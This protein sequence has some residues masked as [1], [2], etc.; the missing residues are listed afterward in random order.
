VTQ[1]V[2]PGVGDSADYSGNFADQRKNSGKNGVLGRSE[3][4]S[5]DHKLLKYLISAEKFRYAVE[6]RNK[7]DRS[8]EFNRVTAE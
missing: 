3:T 1:K 7:I 4:Q 6:Q 8:E 2:A 5:G